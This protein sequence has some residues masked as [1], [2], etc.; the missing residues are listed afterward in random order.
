MNVV[1]IKAPF[2]AP[3]YMWRRGYLFRFVILK[4]I[5]KKCYFV[6]KEVLFDWR[7]LFLMS[8]FRRLF[9]CWFSFFLARGCFCSCGREGCAMS[10]LIW[11]CLFIHLM[12][13]TITIFF[14]VVFCEI[15]CLVSLRRGR[16][17]PCWFVKKVFVEWIGLFVDWVVG[18]F[19]FFSDSNFFFEW[20]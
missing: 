16:F 11:G 8:P 6:L 17:F 15:F 7:K 12:T 13:F 18:E 4:F 20:D 3:F 9:C 2:K 5:V 19:V 10:Y 1:D 14:P